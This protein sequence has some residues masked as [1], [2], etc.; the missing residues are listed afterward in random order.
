VSA[1]DPIGER[2]GNSIQRPL[3]SVAPIAVVTIFVVAEEAAVVDLA[4]VEDTT[5]GAED[6]EEVREGAEE[7]S[8]GNV[9][10]ELNY[11]SVC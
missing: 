11:G 2:N 10:C 7:V 8:N 5:A 3:V 1:I 9:P 6:T 4:E